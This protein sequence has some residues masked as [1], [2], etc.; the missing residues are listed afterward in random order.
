MSIRKSLSIFLFTF[1]SALAI[2]TPTHAADIDMRITPV[3]NYFSLEV[4]A[5]HDYNLTI[6]N[7]GSEKFIFQL[8]ASPYSIADAD[9]AMVFDNNSP[10]KYNQIANWISFKNSEGDY[11]KKPQYEIQPGEDKLIQYRIDIP[12]SIPDGGQYCVIFAE[13]ISD[14]ESTTSSINAISRV[15]FSIVGHGAGNTINSGEIEEFWITAPFST[16]DIPVGTK[17]KNTG[18][19]DFEMV[20]AYKVFSIFGKEIYSDN[21]SYIVLPETE[22]RLTLNWDKAP[23]FGMFK[24]RFSVAALDMVRDETK[25]VVIMPTFILIILLILLTIIVLWII[26]TI[27][28]RKERSTR[29]VV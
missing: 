29:L 27:R 15:A 17:V 25:F 7:K 3:S 19:T 12:D 22:R 21:S 5:V 26:I 18:N 28:K 2:T 13:T 20:Y 1:F 11:E 8:Y 24:A 10:T 23:L 14:Q 4:G 6:S 16:D 9:Y